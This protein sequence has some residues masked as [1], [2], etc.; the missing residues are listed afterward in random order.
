[1]NEQKGESGSSLDEIYKLSKD[2]NRM[3]RAMRRDAFIGGIIKFVF[4]VAVFFVLP[5]VL[6]VLYLQP[7][8][9]QLQGAYENL[10]QNVQAVNEASN[11]FEDLKNQFPN[12][13]DVLK[14][15]GGGN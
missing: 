15:F 9:E 8:L 1:M 3:L 12:I 7:Y 2:N 13:G 4:W 6:Y 10:N 14:Q 11:Q 5:Y